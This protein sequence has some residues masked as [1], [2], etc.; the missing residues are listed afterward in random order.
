MGSLLVL[1][2]SVEKLCLVQCHLEHC[3]SLGTI[4]SEGHKAIRE[5]PKEG[6]RDGG[7]PGEQG[8]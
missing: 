5:Y 4:M 2:P 7:G 6:Y 8:I 1:L 3:V